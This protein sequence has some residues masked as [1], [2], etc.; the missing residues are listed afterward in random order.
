[1]LTEILSLLLQVAASLLAGA[2]LL[3]VYMQYQRIPFGNPVGRFIFAITDWIVLPL[4]KV[5]PKARIDVAGLVAAYLIVLVHTSLLWLLLSRGGYGWVPLSAVFALASMAIWGLIVLVVI[6]AVLSWVRADS[7]AADVIDRLCAPLLRPF[8]RIIPLV[9][10]V[11]LSPLA[12]LVLLQIA[13]IV[14]AGL[15]RAVF[16][17]LA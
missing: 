16:A 4:R 6:C 11:D 13:L 2:C 17:A 5:L 10:G 12:L 3:R 15:Q 8:R 1:M 14:L 9:G 7:P